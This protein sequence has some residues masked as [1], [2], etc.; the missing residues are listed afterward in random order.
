MKAALRLCFRRRLP[1]GGGRALAD[2]QDFQQA[3]ADV[4]P[5]LVGRNYGGTS[6]IK[7]LLVTQR[8]LARQECTGAL[9]QNPK[10]FASPAFPVDN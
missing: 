2:R 10:R 5:P 6:R 7:R 9:F 4:G 3:S 8:G 1:T